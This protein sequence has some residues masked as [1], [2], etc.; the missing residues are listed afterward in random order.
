MAYSFREHSPIIENLSSVKVRTFSCGDEDFTFFAMHWHPRMEI[1]RIDEGELCLDFGNEKTSAKAGEA[2]ILLPNQVHKGYSNGKHVKYRVIMFDLDAFYNQTGITQEFLVPI[3][4]SMLVYK[5]I[6]SHPNVI[7]AIDAISKT[8]FEEPFSLSIV[9]GIYQFIYEFYIHCVTGEQA[10]S[11]FD[12]KMYEVIDYIENHYS[13]KISIE[14]LSEMFGYSLP[15]FCK[16]FKES[17]GLSPTNYINIFRI[18]KALRMIKQGSNHVTDI[19]LACGFSDANYF[20]RCFKAHCGQS[21]THYMKK[22][23]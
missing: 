5:K 19:A 8:D 14:L 16:K 22:K 6:T 4:K 21:P 9:A 10:L 3:Q 15:Y 2:V 7:S 11:V 12:K 20:S 1:L 17:T 18:E 23:E 13:S